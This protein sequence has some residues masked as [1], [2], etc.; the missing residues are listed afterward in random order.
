MKKITLKDGTEIPVLGQGT[1]YMGENPAKK[2]Q[3]IE[4]LRWGIEHDMNLIDT[5]EMYGEGASEELV[6]E[7]IA[8]YDRS[9]LF[10]VSKVYPWNAGR[11]HIFQSCRNSLKRLGTDYLDM[12]LL[13]WR[14]DV[15]FEETVDCM[16]ELVEEGLIRRWGV[17]NLDVDDM[18][19]LLDAGGDNC[20]ADQVLYH[21]GSR[22]AEVELLP[23]LQEHQMPM[24]AY[25]PL[26]QAGRLKASLLQNPEIQKVA[27]KHHV[28]NVQ[29]LLAFVLSRPYTFTVPKASSLEHVKANRAAAD[30]ILDEEDLKRLDA[31]F[32]KPAYVNG[33]DMA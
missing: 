25:C 4:T 16:E 26:A 29:I 8:P 6:G 31:S 19:E 3:E 33:L 17:S 12:Y 21:L 27:D 24:M 2:E 30:I 9:K 5:A 11:D 28:T 10:I 18:E 20:M 13:H 14:G 22:G 23:W 1:W 32:P 15:P 7:A